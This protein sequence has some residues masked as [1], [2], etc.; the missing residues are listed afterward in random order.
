VWDNAT[1]QTVNIGKSFK[2]QGAPSRHHGDK[3]LRFRQGEYHY[4][5]AY[6]RKPYVAPPRMG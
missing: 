6:R 2:R 4:E 5:P 1:S 3:S